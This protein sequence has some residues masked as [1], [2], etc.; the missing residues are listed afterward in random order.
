MKFSGSHSPVD[1]KTTGFESWKM[2]ALFFFAIEC[3][4]YDNYTNFHLAYWFFV[5]KYNGF[6]LVP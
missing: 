2:F 1:T 4:T 5:L 3:Y 6:F